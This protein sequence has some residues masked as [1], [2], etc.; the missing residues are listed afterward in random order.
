MSSQIRLDM[1]HDGLRIQI[2]D[3][4]RGPMFASGSAV[5]EPY[6]RELLREIGGVLTEVPNRLTLEGHTDAQPFGAG[7]RGYSNWEL[8]ADRANAS[9]RELVAG[10]LADDR[11]LR[12]QGLAAS[13]PFD[14]KDPLAPTNRRISIIVMTRDA[15]ERV[16]TGGR[17]LQP[18]ACDRARSRHRLRGD[19]LHHARPASPARRR[20]GPLRRD[21]R[22]AAP[23]RGRARPAN[24]R[25][26]RPLIG[27]KP[28]R[29]GRTMAR[30]S[31]PSWPDQLCLTFTAGEP[32]PVPP[33]EHSPTS[34]TEP[35]PTPHRTASS[36]PRSARS[37]R[38]AAKARWRA[39][40]T[41]VTSAPWARAWRC[42]P[43]SRP[44]S[45]PG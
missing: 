29:R 27:L 25:R 19:R 9:R 17:L 39:R 28:A 16:F 10:G 20:T 22:R 34:L 24:T 31:S 2:V 4:D 15:E 6:M 26:I 12:V 3:Q 13:N 42:W 21:R 43:S 41:S 38:R 7:E 32:G 18:T 35:W 30:L 40:A 11:V 5:V 1:T 45:P 36:P 8:S 14:R 37:R 23:R 33:W 44:T